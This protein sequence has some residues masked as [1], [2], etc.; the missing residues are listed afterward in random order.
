MVA[1]GLQQCFAKF[2]AQFSDWRRRTFSQ[3]KSV[4]DRAAAEA[5][6]VEFDDAQAFLRWPALSA[7]TAHWDEFSLL[8][9]WWN[10]VV[11]ADMP[12]PDVLA[13]EHESKLS[14]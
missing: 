4:F 9:R 1:Q 3:C 13:C 12:S 11:L 8:G 14:S 5:A 2:V 10:D 6:T 7:A